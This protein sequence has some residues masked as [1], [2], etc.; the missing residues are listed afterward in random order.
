ME[1]IEKAPAKINLGLDV[2]YKRNDGYH[3]LEMIMASIDLADRLTFTKT[4]GND[5]TITTNSGF[6]P[7]D[8][9][10]NIFQAI[11]AMK[12]RYAFEGGIHVN[13]QKNIPVAAGLGGGSSDAAATFRGINRLFNLE[14]TLEEMTELAIPIGTDIP[15]CL[16]GETA[17]VTGLGEIVTPLKRPIPQSWVVLVKPKISVSTPRVF[18]KID[19]DT[20]THPNIKALQKAI[21]DNNYTEMTQHLGNSL[22]S[23]TMKKFPVVKM[24][25]E[26]MLDFGVDAAVMSGSG[27]TVIALCDKHSR[28]IHI[29]NSLKG[30][31]QEVYVVRTLNQ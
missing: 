27:P 9:K 24:I 17:L 28:A 8:R 14:A 22:E 1:I 13:L 25:K 18:S 3:E 15:F 6:L 12:K 20:L 10:N 26:K 11:E 5:I 2:L 4:E 30:F 23:Y 16:K 19:V 29:A 7:T 31:C 21:E